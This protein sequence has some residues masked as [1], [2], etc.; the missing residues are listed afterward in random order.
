M[1]RAAPA[2]ATLAPLMWLTGCGSDADHND[3][4][5]EFATAMIEHH[6]QAIQMANFT[7]GRDGLDP[8]IAGLAEQIRVDQTEEIDTMSAWLEE[9]GEPVP[10]TGFA[11]GDGHTHSEDS[12]SDDHGDMPGMAS[13]ADM[14]ALAEAP[15]AEFEEQWLAT[16][17]EHHEGAVAMAEEVADA[18]ESPE[19][20]EV[21]ESIKADQQAEIEEMTSWLDET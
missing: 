20:E 7:I 8:Q 11:T 2:L 14:D 19:V 13:G 4:D 3:A 5:V 18:G 15:D 17:L 16:M 1:R 10:E 21:A 9:W 12:G 6:A